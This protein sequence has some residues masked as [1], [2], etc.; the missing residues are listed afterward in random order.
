MQ[1]VWQAAYAKARDIVSEMTVLE[2]VNLTTGIGWGSGPCIGNTGGVPRLD[3]PPL[4]LQDGPNGVRFTD[5]VTSFPSGLAT[6]AT[7]NKDLMHRRGKAIGREAKAKGVHILLAPTIG[8]I[9]YKA[10]GGRNWESFG[11]DPYLQGIAGALTVQGIQEE[12][13]VAVARHFIGNEQE[14]FRQ[15]NE[16]TGGD[17]DRL[18]D[19]IDSQIKDRVMHEIYLWP[20]ADVVHAGVGGVMC[21]YNRVNGTY[22]CEN[23]YLLNYLLKE[24]LGFQGFVVSDWGAQ[25]SG[26]E[27]ALAG[28]DMTM[29][30]EIFGDWCSGKSYWGPLLT[31]SIYNDT[32]PQ[33]RLND[34]V[35]RILAAFYSIDIKLPSEQREEDLPN[36]SSWSFHTYDQEF[37]FQSY[38][39]I[40]QTNY[41]IDARDD[42]TEKTALQVARE[43]IVLLKNDA[44]HLPICTNDGVRRLLVAGKGAGPDPKGFNS[45]DQQSADGALFSGWGSASVNAPYGITPWEAIAKKAR[46]R[47][48]VI[49]YTSDE[50]EFDHVDE[51]AEY[52]DMCI[53]FG[54]ADSGE[55]YIEVDGN[56]G[57][58]KNL[59]LWQN[60]EELIQHIANRCHKTVVVVTAT[61]PVN[62]ESFVDHENVVAVLYTPPLGQFFGAA[63]AD[64]LFGDDNPSGRLPFTIARKDDQ[65]V[66]IIDKIPLKGKPQDD[67]NRLLDYRYF[68]ENGIRPRYEFGFGLSYTKFSLSELSIKEILPPT[69]DLPCP[70]PYLDEY[71][72]AE[73][74]LKDVDDALFPFRDFT[75]VPGYI[76]PYLF[77]EK[78]YSVDEYEYPEGY[79]EEDYYEEP[80]AGGSLGGNEALWNVLYSVKVEV[81]NIGDSE[82][83]YVAQLYIDYPNG[84][85]DIKTP[86]QL[87]GFDKVYVK[88]GETAKI[89]FDILRRDISVWDTEDQSWV[90]NPGTYKLYVGSSSRRLELAG[91][92][93]IL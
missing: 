34:M 60:T 43:G 68:D 28:L 16:W 78:I 31:R 19:S 58:R 5:F 42:F 49:D 8:P 25:H 70:A 44:H 18:T 27:S 90:I 2:K 54:F 84:Y 51:I 20:W 64:V 77:N 22:A 74:K 92:V 53:V 52:A 86:R 7:F 48:M 39:P 41:H 10:Q 83:A 82:G 81:T 3:I 17:W 47:E 76:Y 4:C 15:E 32:I 79:T 73:E 30:G 36:F 55:G 88:P 29:P 80:L 67:L 9:G 45:K 40:K 26:V 14:H 62:L 87:R 46:E 6:G 65:Y 13:V 23:S 59:T 35:T 12:G 57:D 56:F 37:P 50:Y 61:G 69:T 33:S 24:E 21:S 85:G 63:I 91:E 66:D 93:E 75:P 72:Y 1:H 11:S 89:H 38:G 71:V